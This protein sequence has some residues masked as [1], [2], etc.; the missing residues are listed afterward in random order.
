MFSPGAFKLPGAKARGNLIRNG[1][2]HYFYRRFIPA[3]KGGD[4]VFTH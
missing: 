2:T 1:K 3:L 4:F